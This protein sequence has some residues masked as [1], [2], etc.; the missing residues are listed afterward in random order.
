M[1]S[2]QARDILGLGS[3]A[4][5]ASAIRQARNDALKAHHPD[6]AGDGPEAKRRATYWAS[7]I[8][9]AHEVLT[10]ELHGGVR[11]SPASEPA[12]QSFAAAAR[13]AEARAERERDAERE[14]A[15]AAEAEAVARAA[16]DRAA[17]DR[18]AAER[19]FAAERAATERRAAERAASG[20]ASA[21]EGAR[22]RS[23]PTEPEPTTRSGGHRFRIQRRTV[24]AIAA[25][26]VVGSTGGALAAL[27]RLNGPGSAA[28]A[29]VEPSATP[30]PAPTV[31]PTLTPTPAATPRAARLTFDYWA[32]MY[33]RSILPCYDGGTCGLDAAIEY[34][35]GTTAR[36]GPEVDRL[37]ALYRDS[38]KLSFGSDEMCRPELGSGYAL[39]ASLS[40]E[41]DLLRH[42]RKGE[43]PS[44][45]W[46][47]GQDVSFEGCDRP[48]NRAT[49]ED[50][51][52]QLLTEAR[53]RLLRAQRDVAGKNWADA[54][55][56]GDQLLPLGIRIA[57]LTARDDP[58]LA[59]PAWAAD[60][61]LGWDLIRVS[62]ALGVERLAASSATTTLL[63]RCLDE[64]DASPVRPS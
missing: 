43:H 16:A 38:A 12:R 17:A 40:S 37:A 36:F 21:A 64:I 59:S 5:T 30:S 11:P 51:V 6:L 42:L 19:A 22:A 60:R 41:V 18:A 26:L 45:A 2:A 50:D 61:V 3:A 10:N 54:R 1:D 27:A 4:L 49:A 48:M 14:H 23:T 24:A 55:L 47:P 20:T 28:A 35:D 53:D 29:R 57:R 13:R 52:G 34:T 25:I 33:A 62:G 8:N 7:Q 9:A 58:G 32:A 15:A 31:A 39:F 63:T 56:V 44:D 46:R